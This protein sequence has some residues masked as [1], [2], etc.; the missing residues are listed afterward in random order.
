MKPFEFLSSLFFQTPHNEPLNKIAAGFVEAWRL[1]NKPDSVVIFLITE[2]EINIADQRHLE[3][4]LVRQEP[5]I[6][7]ERC[8]LLELYQHGHMSDDRTLF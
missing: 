7:V 1:Y 4:E 6:H 8:T 3:Y 5:R 2:H